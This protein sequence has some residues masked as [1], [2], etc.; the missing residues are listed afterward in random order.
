MFSSRFIYIVPYLVNL[1]INLFTRI[2]ISE[3]N[4]TVV[5]T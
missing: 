5:P 1:F 3:K 4:P 2:L